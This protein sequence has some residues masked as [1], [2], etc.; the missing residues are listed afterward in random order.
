MAIVSTRHNGIPEQ[1]I[2]GKTGLLVHEFDYEA[3]GAEMLKLVN[4]KDLRLSLGTEAR[5]HI[6][7][8]C[9]PENRTKEIETM[10]RKS[11]GV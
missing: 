11:L 5:K 2:E 7:Q 6:L 8:L 1:I 10:I 3:M 9:D 4:D